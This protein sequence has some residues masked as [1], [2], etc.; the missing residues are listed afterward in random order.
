MRFAGAGG[1]RGAECIQGDGNLH[2]YEQNAY[3][4]VMMMMMMMMMLMLLMMMMIIMM[5]MMR[6]GVIYF[7]MSETYMG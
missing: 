3:K 1:S 4:V 2:A 7:L 5:M 6:V